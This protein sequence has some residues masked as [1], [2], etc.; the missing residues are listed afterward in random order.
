MK[1]KSMRERLLASSMIC[2]AALLGLSSQAAAQTASDEISEVVVTGTR[3]PSPNLESVSPVTAVSAAEIK[4]TGVTRVE[5]MINSL[6]Q[7]FAAQGAALSNGSTGTATVS[8][9]G[10]GATRTQVLIDGRRLMPGTPNTLGGSLAADIN[11]IPSALIERVD[12][13][14]GGASAVYGAD[15]VGGVVNFIMAKNFE[16]VRVDAQYGIYQ[17]D[18][19]NDVAGVVQA[20]QNASANPQFFQLPKDN[21]RDGEMSQVTLVIGVNSPDGKGNVTAYAGYRHVEP[22]LQGNRDFSS[23]TFNSGDT[24]ADAGC[25]G[26]GTAFPARVGAYVVDPAGPGNTFRLRNAATDVYNFGP[27]NYYQRPDDRYVLGAFANYEIND[28][29]TAYADVMF[30]D[31][32][33]TYQIAPGGI[34]AGTFSVNCA[35]PFLS[36]QQRGLLNATAASGGGTCATNPAGTFTGTI[37][38]RNVEGGGRQGRTQHQQYRYVVGVRGDLNDNWNYDFAMQYGRV[39]FNQVQTGFYRTSAINQALNVVQTPSGPACANPAG[40]CVPY[41]IFQLGG[42]TQD[43][44]DF[45]ETPSTQNGNLFERIVNFS[46]GGDLTEYGVKSPWANDG[47]GVSMGAEYRRETLDFAADFISSSGDLNGSG[48]ANPPVNGSFDVYELFAETRIPIVQDMA[49]AK[50]LTLE[51][52]FRYSDYSS[53]GTT[54]TYKIAGDWEP[55]DGLRLRGGYNRAVRAP[56]VLELF[57]PQNVVLDGT[58]D[59]CAGLAASDPLVARCAQAFNLTAAQVLAIEANPANQYNGQIG[60]NPNLDP[61]TADTWTVGFVYQPSFLP[62]FNFSADW[63]SIKV[64]DFISGIGADTIINRCVNTLDSFFCGLVNRDQDGSIWLSNEGYVVDTTLNTGALRTKG[65]DFN[66]S[67]RTD[68]ENF[69]ISNG[70]GLSF[71]FVGTWL[72]D[73]SIQNLPG[74][75]FFNCAG[76]YGTI[77]SVS[78][79]L[80]SPNPEWRHKARV[81][82]TTPFEYGDWFKDFSLS[83]QWRHFNKVT[84]DAYSDD[85]ALNNPGLQYATDKTLASRDYFD[86]TASWTMRDNLNFRA[87]VNNLFDKDPPLNG[88]SNCP[89]GPCNGNT[90][91]QIYDAFGRYLFI[92]L[93]ADF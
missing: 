43:A 28:W 84:L 89:T 40:G 29:A 72:D 68:L 52:A 69:G 59:P 4:A 57:S 36:A 55:I 60:G 82:W 18:N 6:P 20:A 49:F 45:L 64:K 38:R 79:G 80:S 26:S 46:L 17:H 86:L 1:F 71:N 34:F 31:D 39:S 87:G 67:Y 33:S 44:L 74:D 41:N 7:A 62:G 24:F 35:N 78:G 50:S 32:T 76:Y 37:S 75:D 9:R 27:T 58:Q 56:H 30:M 42:V 21:V 48:G 3:I 13:L 19:G 81:T 65:I 5:D 14:T 8:L 2:G 73:L 53:I 85:P 16:G 93:T 15:A 92:G 12:V 88:S 70:G 23:C 54:E 61:E 77:C 63:F 91:P 22:I 83:L 11:F 90:W 51:L 47:V 25:G 66:V 10:L